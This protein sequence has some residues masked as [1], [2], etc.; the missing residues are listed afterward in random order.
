[1]EALDHCDR[2]ISHIE[3]LIKDGHPD[4]QGL[5]LGLSDWHTERRL[6]LESLQD[7]VERIKLYDQFL[8]SKIPISPEAGISTSASTLHHTRSSLY[9]FQKDIVDWALRRGRAA[10][11]ADCGLGKTPM[12]LYW[13]DAI[14]RHTHRAVLIFAPVAVADQTEDEAQKFGVFA[15]VVGSPEDFD[16]TFPIVYISNYEKLHWFESKQSGLGGIVLDESSILKSFDGHF[17]QSIVNFASSI[18]YRLACTAT[19]APN[20]LVELCNHAD[21]LDI[22]RPKEVKA[23][24]F[25]QNTDVQGQAHTWRLKHHAEEDFWSWL[26][27]WSVSIRKP[28][29]LGYENGAFQLPPL[30]FI[31]HSTKATNTAI[32]GIHGRLSS[33]R[34]SLQDRVRVCA[35][36]ANNSSETWLIWCNL[37]DESRALVQAIPDAV[38]LTGSM[39]ERKKEQALH[40]FSSGRIRVLVTK[41]SIAGFGMNWQHCHNTAF[42]GLSD[43]YEQLYQA[44]RRCWRFGQR[45]KVYAHI[46]TSESEQAVIEN[47][48]RKE[49]QSSRIMTELVKRTSVYST[50]NCMRKNMNYKEE[51]DFGKGWSMCLG[52]SVRM[53]D[54]VPCMSTP[55]AQMM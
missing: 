23:L 30:E 2:E 14:V 44:V 28:S 13:A 48:K 6:I 8:A 9:P 54:S 50:A 41:P 38:E 15:N 43:S 3:K 55:I 34:I 16:P 46:I 17:R 12:Q 11:F 31:E 21:F 52:D 33:R 37:N 26:A 42:V 49:E 32:S 39:P 51:A 53:L 29:D 4:L 27:S 36:L 1:M 47:I 19:P 40:G 22:M 18:P 25:K 24:F 35:D 5:T 7:P 20:D 10:I 45:H